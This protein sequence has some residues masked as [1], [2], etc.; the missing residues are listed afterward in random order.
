MATFSV[1]EAFLSFIVGISS[2][3]KLYISCATRL[4]VRMSFSLLRISALIASM[5]SDN[6][7]NVRV[8]R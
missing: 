3:M 6:C 7:V 8:C 1:F 4:F 2:S 5:A